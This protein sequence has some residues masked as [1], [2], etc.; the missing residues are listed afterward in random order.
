MGS[1]KPYNTRMETNE[2]SEPLRAYET[3]L[4]ATL[5]LY[6][7]ALVSGANARRFE[8]KLN[9]S[10]K[11]LEEKEDKIRFLLRFIQEV[12]EKGGEVLAGKAKGILEDI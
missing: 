8:H 1:K 3:S 10:K 12:A 4:K 6:Q 5:S 9:L 2:Q 7:A 11:A